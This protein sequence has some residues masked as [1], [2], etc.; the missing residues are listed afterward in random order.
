MKKLLFLILYVLFTQTY[1]QIFKSP[2]EILKII[3]DSPIVYELQPL[4]NELKPKQNNGDVLTPIYYVSQTDSG[5]MVLKY[6]FSDENMNIY[7]KA[8]EYFLVK[9]LDTALIYYKRLIELSPNISTYYDHMGAV[10]DLQNDTAG[11]RACYQKAITINPFD[12]LAHGC[13]ANLYYK[14]TKIDEAL[15]EVV[16]AIILNR[17]D[18][19][20]VELFEK[21]F[22][23]AHHKNEL[24]AFNPQISIERTGV[25]KATV[26]F[27]ERW[28]GY[29][30][31]KAVWEYEPDY[32]SN[33]KKKFNL[34]NGLLSFYKEKECLLNEIN[35]LKEVGT[36]FQNDTQLQVLNTSYTSN[37]LDAYLLFDV[38][39]P[40]N[41]LLVYY[42]S[43]VM[44]D[45]LK[46]YII[47]VRNPKL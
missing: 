42:Q 2:A 35:T 18:S 4:E 14:Q 28:V 15:Q 30:L 25:N 20:V 13:L 22:Q 7:N 16:I 46:K 38:L 33:I 5:A 36:D 39:S 6:Q 41:P 26:R 27:D 24:W 31:A 3:Y 34:T 8:T 10:L 17:N 47:E 19:W 21:I 44:M 32:Q 12:G 40:S 23:A 9:N 37:M 45:M 1:G 29:A 11:E 43:Q